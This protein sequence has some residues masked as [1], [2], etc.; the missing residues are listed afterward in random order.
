MGSNRFNNKV[1]IKYSVKENAHV[2]IQIYNLSGRRANTLINNSTVKAGIHRES[3]N[4]TDERG[5]RI[6]NGVYFYK[7][8]IGKKQFTGRLIL[9]K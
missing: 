8:L 2:T 4:G 7:L 1:D 5:N 6:E 3:W 9:L